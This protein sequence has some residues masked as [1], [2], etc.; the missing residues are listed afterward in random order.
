MLGHSFSRSGDHDQA[1]SSYALLARH[2]SPA[3]IYP[4]LCLAMEFLRTK[5]VQSAN[6][7]LVEAFNADRTNPVIMNEIGV[8]YCLSKNYVKAI[9][10]LH[11]AYLTWKKH[12]IS[13]SGDVALPVLILSNLLAV[14]LKA[15]PSMKDLV[16]EIR[17][18]NQVVGELLTNHI[19][20]PVKALINC[21]AILE[22]K[23]SLITS[24]D[25][26]QN[27]VLYGK[28]A[29]LY[30]SAVQMSSAVQPDKM[31]LLGY[32]R[33]LVFKVQNSA[34]PEIEDNSDTLPM[35]SSE[36]DMTIDDEDMPILSNTMVTPVKNQPRMDVESSPIAEEEFSTISRPATLRRRLTT[37]SFSPTQEDSDQDS[38]VL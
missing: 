10:M 18:A 36:V 37:L 21:A 14:Y 27:S 7:Y 28:A 29:D 26:E 6:L 16:L 15:V 4:R 19:N 3:S 11:S 22:L 5:Q 34:I 32:N 25:D 38:Q 23:A 12:P 9:N 8:M 13:T 30:H 24:E 1:V 35:L 17:T 20:L 31:A 2:T 33:C